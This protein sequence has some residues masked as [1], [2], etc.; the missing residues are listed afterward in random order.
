MKMRQTSAEKRKNPAQYGRE[1]RV[2][3]AEEIAGKKRDER[4]PRKRPVGSSRTRVLKGLVWLVPIHKIVKGEKKLAE[5]V[6]GYSVSHRGSAGR[7]TESQV[8]ITKGRRDNF[9]KVKVG[10]WSK[11]RSA[12]ETTRRRVREKTG[13]TGQETSEQGL[14]SRLSKSCVVGHK[15]QGDRK[16]KGGGEKEHHLGLAL[17]MDESRGLR[18]KVYQLKVPGE[19]G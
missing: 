12:L 10:K 1:K 11:N 6:M 13:K 19:G 2:V 17:L 16:R 5:K 7:L 4:K 15:R 3:V 8:G 18:K 9:Q 14:R